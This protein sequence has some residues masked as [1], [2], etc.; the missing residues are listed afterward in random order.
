MGWRVR[1]P[2]V[3]QHVFGAANSGGP[4][5]A[6]DRLTAA[7]LENEFVFH[8]MPQPGPAGGINLG[9][10]SHFRKEV[11]R[12]RPD[13]VHV[14]G[15]GN[16]GFHGALAARLAGVK[17][18]LVSVHGTVRDLQFPGSRFRNALVRDALEPAT[19]RMASHI[20]TVCHFA[21][22]REFLHPH[23]N[24]LI[25]VV[26][27]GVEIPARG[28]GRSSEFRKQFGVGADDVVAVCVSRITRE[29]GYFLLA[30]SLAKLPVLE[31]VLHLWIVGDGPDRAEIEAAMP[32]RNDL[33]V[34]FLGHRTDVGRV[35]E[36]GDFFLFPSLHENLSNALLE[37]MSHGLPAIAFAVGG[38]TEVVVS[39][40][41]VLIPLGN[42][43]SFSTAIARYVLDSDVRQVHGEFAR[44][45]VAKNF[46]MRNMIEGMFDVYRRVLSEDVR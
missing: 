29:K 21:A 36:E 19:L 14:R 12:I 42:V 2:V 17:R 6:L 34:R 28:A 15:L 10:L 20:L 11:L 31:R 18:I 8:R 30:E 25:G 41:G 37:A 23:R 22:K 4:I 43:D 7:N 46:S 27:N 35:L 38:N 1:K 13:M 33:E 39:D 44:E 3:V 5:V 40:T 45:H 24:K 16:E 32:R 9:L 26:H